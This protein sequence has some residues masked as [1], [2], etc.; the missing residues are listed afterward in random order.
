[1]YATVTKL[2]CRQ[3]KNCTEAYTRKETDNRKKVGRVRT[4]TR[5]ASRSLISILLAL[6]QIQTTSLEVFPDA[7]EVLGLREKCRE[8]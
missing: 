2:A 5:P 4:T 6:Q 1:M 7:L 8:P 3:I